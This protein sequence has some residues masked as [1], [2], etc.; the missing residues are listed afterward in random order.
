MVKLELS[1]PVLTD[2]EKIWAAI[3]ELKEFD[4]HTLALASKVS[5]S[6]IND[7]L[8]GLEK[9]GFL[10]AKRAG[11]GKFNKYTLIKD[12]GA[13]APRVKKNGVLLPASGRNR[14]WKVMR[15]LKVFTLRELVNAASIAGSEIAY[16]EAEHYC[17]WLTRAGYLVG[18]SGGG[19]A[20]RF[21]SAMNTG[22][23][24]PQILRVKELYDPNTD[25]VVYRGLAEG[26]DDV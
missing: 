16:S 10:Q 19:G 13:Q 23:K 14:M 24:A 1:C 18:T 6:K 11:F 15:V 7:Y 22:P 12:T 5:R 9:A 4:A 8:P 20:Y 25:K 3:R 2:R 21:I 17:K 26:R